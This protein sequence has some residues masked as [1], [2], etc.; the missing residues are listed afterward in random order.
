MKRVSQV[1]QVLFFL[2]MVLA[3]SL[4]PVG[5]TTHKGNDPSVN[6]AASA[7]RGTAFC[8][9]GAVGRSHRSGAEHYRQHYGSCSERRL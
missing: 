9:D 3:V 6:E 5:A 1:V 4:A 7:K 8:S 2:L